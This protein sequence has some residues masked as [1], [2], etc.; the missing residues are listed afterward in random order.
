MHRNKAIWLL[1][2]L[3]L[4]AYS[5]TPSTDDRGVAHTITIFR[6]GA[7]GFAAASLE[8]EQAVRAIQENDTT[9]INTAK[10]ALKKCRLQYKR[11]EFFL[12]YFFFSSSMVYNRP[13]KTEIDEP[14]M[15]Y[16]APS[17]LQ[18]IAVPLFEKDPFT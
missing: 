11:I 4:A 14:Y 18:Q 15:E 1:C 2:S 3:L 16:Q 17:G 7:A 9:S 6:E 12:D 5:F 8:L 10:E 13:A